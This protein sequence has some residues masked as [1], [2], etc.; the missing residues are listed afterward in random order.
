MY[1]SCLVM[2][3][4][5]SSINGNGYKSFFV[6]TFNLWKFT[7]ICNFPFLFGTSKIGESHVASS[8][9]YI[10]PN[11]NNLLMFYLSVIT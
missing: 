1:D 9:G 10:K 3:L 8:I 4:N 2:M 6:V 7:Q 11:V 5:I